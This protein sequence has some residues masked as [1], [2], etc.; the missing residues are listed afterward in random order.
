MPKKKSGGHLT[1]LG[2]LTI[3]DGLSV[4]G[5]WRTK[6]INYGRCRRLSS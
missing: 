1:M 2:R 6:T 3:E 5:D 4:R